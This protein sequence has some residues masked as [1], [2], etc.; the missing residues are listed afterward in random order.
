MTIYSAFTALTSLPALTA[1]ANATDA[2]LNGIAGWAVSIMESLGGFGVAF[3]IALENLFPPLPSEI[4]LPLAG[5]TASQGTQFGLVEAIVWATVGSLVGAWALYGIAR[6]IGRERTRAIFNWL[7]LVKMS[8]VDKTEAWFHKH[9]QSTVFFGR[10]LP[11]FRSLISLPAGVI[12]MNFVKFTLLTAAG[13]AIWNTALVGAGYVLGENWHLVENYVGI[14]SK[15]V[16]GALLLALAW[17]VAVRL[18]SRSTRA[19]D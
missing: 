18:R 7:P 6:V 3:L 9:D 17:W 4:I 15:I 14:L 10:M 5:F 19:A 2:E 1:T 13:A 11:I 8:D 16:L 12:K